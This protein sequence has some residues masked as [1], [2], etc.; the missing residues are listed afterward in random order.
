MSDF[1]DINEE[2]EVRTIMLE[3]EDGTEVECIIRAILEVEGNM[4]A[5]LLPMGEDEYQ[6]YGFAENGD[7]VEIINIEDENEYEIVLKAFDDY[8]YSEEDFEEEEYDSED[9]EVYDYSIDD[10]EKK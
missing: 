2:I 4:Y 10:E 1:E 3:Y 5:A 7:D 6:I 9:D 8:F